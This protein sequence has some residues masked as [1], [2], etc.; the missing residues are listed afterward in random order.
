[1]K[2]VDASL[3]KRVDDDHLVE[4][5]ETLTKAV[6]ECKDKESEGFQQILDYLDNAMEMNEKVGKR[7]LSDVVFGE[8]R[9]LV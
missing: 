5:M 3:Q 1:M 6:D 9:H 2:L 8:R 4:T 7:V